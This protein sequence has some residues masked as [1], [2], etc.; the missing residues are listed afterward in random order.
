MNSKIQVYGETE[1]G[2]DYSIYITG[3]TMW[4]TLWQ[5]QTV[6]SLAVLRNNYVYLDKSQQ[7]YSLN[8]NYVEGYLEYSTN[9]RSKN[10][11]N[12]QNFISY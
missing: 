11:L 3:E 5:K 10:I 2:S 9:N 7:Y 12:N 1:V 8:M 6:Q 4:A